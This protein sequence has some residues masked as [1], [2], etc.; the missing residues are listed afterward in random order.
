MLR[1]F[2]LGEKILT[3]NTHDPD[4]CT[5]AEL[6]KRLMVQIR[7]K[8]AELATRRYDEKLSLFWS[9]LALGYTIIFI[10]A[11]TVFAVTY[12]SVK[13][14]FLVDTVEIHYVLYFQFL[15]TNCDEIPKSNYFYL[16]YIIVFIL[17]L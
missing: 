7:Q 10:L 12:N 9:K 6:E 17:K 16:D 1:E 13:V 2:Y 11:F 8:Y 3:L 5:K 14:S 4:C 15:L